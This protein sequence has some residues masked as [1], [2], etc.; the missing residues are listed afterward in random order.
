[1]TLVDDALRLAAQGWAVHPL[2]KDDNGFAKKA[3]TRDWQKITPDDWDSL[4][5]ERAAGIGVIGGSNSG[6]L[7]FI[8]VDHGGLA[9]D[10]AAYLIR[11]HRLP[12][13]AW[14]ARARIHVYVQETTP[15]TYQSLSFAYKGEKATVELRATGSYVAC[16]PTPGYTWANADFEPLY[17]SVSAVWS[18]LLRSAGLMP[19]TASL[20]T[21]GLAS[22]S[23]GYPKPWAQTVGAGERNHSLFIEAATLKDAGMPFDEALALMQLRFGKSYEQGGLLWREAA[24]TIRSAFNRPVRVSTGQDEGIVGKWRR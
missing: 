12:L 6:N 19:Y 7:A 24:R 23:P 3:I 2:V 22:S 20:N 18:E 10:L 11:S 15:S 5:W 16:P 8:D 1:M 17:G 9:A 13:M 21:L 4:D 14:T